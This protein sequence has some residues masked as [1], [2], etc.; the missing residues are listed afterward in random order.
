MK[1]SLKKLLKILSVV[2]IVAAVGITIFGSSFKN[3]L[4]DT[5]ANNSKVSSES[6]SSSDKPADTSGLSDA[7]VSIIAV[8]DDLLHLSLIESMGKDAEGHYDFHQIF[9]GVKTDVESADLAIINQ[10]TILGGEE[11]GLSGYPCFNSPW[12][13]GDALVD[14]GFDVVLGASNHALD[15]GKQ[16]VLN[17]VNFWKTKHPEITLLGLNDSE[18]MQNKI[19]IVEKNGIK[20]AMLNYTYGTN[21]IPM[22]KDTPYAVNML[23]NKEKVLS[24]IKRAKESADVV[25]VFPH[26]GAEYT[27]SP[28]AYQDGW[29]ETFYDNGVDIVIGG[30]THSIQPLEM[31]S[32]DGGRKMPVFYS[33]GNFVS[34]QK[35]WQTMLGS[36]AKL[37]VERK[38]G[39][40]EITSASA[41]PVVT[42]YEIYWHRDPSL[43]TYKLCDYTDELASRHYLKVSK[44]QLETLAKEVY[45]EYLE[46]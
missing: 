28:N 43:K 33:L 39:Q 45:G 24:D 30:H 26:W 5:P 40:I 8:G 31:Y 41:V 3:G 35:E 13:A 22:P 21:G 18:E 19:N 11:L 14:T 46:Y 25:I 1:D 9:T 20:F 29:T 23:D 12:S 16:G 32:K 38:N 37:T 42:H 44:K 36:M 15:K 27:Y 4:S 7:K 17:T 10:E 2:I 6:I 34:G